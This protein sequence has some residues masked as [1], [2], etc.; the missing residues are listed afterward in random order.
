MDFTI[1][2]VNFFQLIILKK[3]QLL[4]ILLFKN[5]RLRYSYSQ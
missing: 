3:F 2:V 1:E 5:F 4:K